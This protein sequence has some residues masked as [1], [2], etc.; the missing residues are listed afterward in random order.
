[1]VEVIAAAVEAETL[2]GEVAPQHLQA[3][4][5]ASPPLGQRQAEAAELV[6]RVAHADAQ[7]DAAAAEVV[8]HGQARG[9]P[10]RVVERQQADVRGE[11]HAPRPRRHGGRH[12]RPRRQ[13]AVVHEVVLGEPHQVEAEAV[14]PGDLLEDLGVEPR[15]V[16]V[17]TGRVAEVVDDP[18][19]KRRSRHR[20][21]IIGPELDVPTM[22]LR[23][24]LIA[25]VLAA[26]VPVL[27]FATLVIWDNAR[28][29]LATTER[30]MRETAHAVAGTVDKEL[31][32]AITALAALGESEQ[33]GDL[34]RF[35][36]LCQRVV[37]AQ[38]WRSILLFAADGT[39]LM[40]T[41]VP[42]GL[43]MGSTSPAQLL[44]RARDERRPTVSGLFDGIRH[45]RIVSVYVPVVREDRVRYV[46]A[47]GLPA[48]RFGEVL[49][50]QQFGH[51]TVAV[52][53]DREHVIVAGTQ[54][55]AELVGLRVRNPAPGAEGWTRGAS[56]G[57][58]VYVA[59]S[60]ASL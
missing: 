21:S 33:L 45:P 37:Q 44:A 59:Y 28:L 2:A 18:D 50:A 52:L 24:H 11:P 29:Q 40:H 8:Q 30:G 53:Q 19:T 23:S 6:G 13:V 4:L 26:L 35:H 20:S 25:L 7:L 15:R 9:E 14:E 27:G 48:G 46:L 38:G 3:S 31:E 36:A 43:P 1:G 47:A 22:R 58:D 12:R 39:G 5:R 49:R 42:L 57:G 41:G 10:Q 60:T 32:T 17:G 55:A 16:E 54:S 56:R 34:R 51:G